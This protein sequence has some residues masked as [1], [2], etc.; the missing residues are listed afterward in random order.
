[1]KT[2]FITDAFSTLGGLAAVAY[3]NP[4]YFREV[5][6]QIFSS[7]ATRFVDAHTPSDVFTSMVPSFGKITERVVSGL[8][9]EYGKDEEFTDY[10]DVEL[11]PLWRDSIKSSFPIEFSRSLEGAS[12]YDETLSSYLESSLSRVLRGFTEIENLTSS[13]LSHLNSDTA[14]TK[15]LAL[16]SKV[17][18]NNPQGKVSVPPKD[19]KVFLENSVELGSDYKGVEFAKAYLTPADYFS[20]VPIPG[21]TAPGMLPTD[22]KSSILQ[23]YSGYP[24]GSKLESLFN[25]AGSVSIGDIKDPGAAMAPADTFMAASILGT[26][27]KELQA[28]RDIYSISLMGEQLNG[29]TTFDPSTMS[30]GELIDESL[31][32]DM[33]LGEGVP[34][35]LKDFIKTYG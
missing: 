23:G 19:S 16:I 12:T 1:M 10:V 20:N 13:V 6:D 25:P 24:T 32:P 21:M 29:Y 28:D 26:F 5:K 3:G 15:D 27:P 35:F 7:S 30:N 2:G 31:A 8:E 18:T 22:I 4:N 9:L 11:G 17:V 33:P 34:G 14:L